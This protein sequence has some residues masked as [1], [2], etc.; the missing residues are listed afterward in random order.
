MERRPNTQPDSGSRTLT[1]TGAPPQEGNAGGPSE[2]VAGVLKL[3][4]G[5][6]RRQ[7][8]VW[9][10]DTIDNEGMGKKKSKSKS[11]MPHESP[12]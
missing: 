2:P 8:V 4:G 12:S 7:K 10:E 9:R 5:P 11:H 1:Q 3:R 6:S